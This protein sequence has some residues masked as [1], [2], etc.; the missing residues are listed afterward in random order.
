M[1]LYKILYPMDINLIY[2][3]KRRKGDKSYTTLYDNLKAL[4]KHI[5][6]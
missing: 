4:Y 6:K 3:D 5:S 1:E 2:L